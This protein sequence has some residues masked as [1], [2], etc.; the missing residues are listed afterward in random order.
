[1]V[2]RSSAPCS[3]SA[4]ISTIGTP[5][6]P[7][8]PTDSVA[9][10]GMSATASAA[11]ATILFTLRPRRGRVA[12]RRPPSVPYACVPPGVLPSVAGLVGASIPGPALGPD[13][14]SR[15]TDPPDDPAPRG[16]QPGA[17]PGGAARGDP[18]RSRECRYP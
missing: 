6:S 1:M 17:T 3:S 11:D 7:N 10:D 13:R 8:P 12:G 18:V 15:R 16:D 9:P 2:T 14:R 4:S 5:H